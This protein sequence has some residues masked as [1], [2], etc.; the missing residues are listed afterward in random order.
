MP[1]LRH[2]VIVASGINDMDASG[3]EMLSLI[4]DRVRSMGY[5]LSLVGVNENVLGVLKR[6]HLREKIGES[7]IFSTISAAVDT[8]H[9][10][11]H[12]RCAQGQCPLQSVCFIEKPL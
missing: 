1:E 8:I 11:A 10:R 12:T 7:N 3:E 9:T 5:D 2:I 4:L 6:T